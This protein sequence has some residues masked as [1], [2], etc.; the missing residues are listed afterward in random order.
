[1][2]MNASFLLDFLRAIQGEEVEFAYRDAQNVC[3]IRP[4]KNEEAVEYYVMPI[5]TE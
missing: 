5:V 1:M 2:G 4:A 3:R